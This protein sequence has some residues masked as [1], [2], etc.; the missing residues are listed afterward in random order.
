MDP[1]D[2][3]P[4]GRQVGLRGQLDLVERV[5]QRPAHRTE[6]AERPGGELD[7]RDVP[8]HVFQIPHG[9]V[10]DGAGHVAHRLDHH[11]HFLP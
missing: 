1:G 2:L 6:R 3:G 5:A 9:G 10:R 7:P 4:L 8:V 11:V